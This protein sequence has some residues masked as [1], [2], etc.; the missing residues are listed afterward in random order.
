MWRLDAE[1]DI[2][3][4]IADI[5]ILNIKIAGEVLQCCIFLSHVGHVVFFLSPMCHVSWRISGLRMTSVLSPELDADVL[6]ED[7]TRTVLF[8]IVPNY[9]VVG[10]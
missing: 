7:G 6:G 4:I 1:F 8:L 10:G 9:K 3:N 5:L 2:E